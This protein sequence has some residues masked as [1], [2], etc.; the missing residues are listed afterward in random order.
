MRHDGDSLTG[1]YEASAI[2]QKRAGEPNALD[3]AIIEALKT[4][5]A[6]IAAMPSRR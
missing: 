5:L 3:L 6:R 2:Y 1:V 4:C